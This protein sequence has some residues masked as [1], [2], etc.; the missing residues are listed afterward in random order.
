MLGKKVN[1]SDST[2]QSGGE[3]GKHELET[4]DRTT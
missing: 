3:S 1:D 4:K 2:Q